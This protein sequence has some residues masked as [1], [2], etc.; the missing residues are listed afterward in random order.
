MQKISIEEAIEQI[1]KK[2]PR[3]P[4]ESYHFIREI[5]DFTIKHFKKNTLGSDRHVS[6]KELLEGVRLYSLQ[7][8]GPLAF[9]VLT[10]WNLR[11]C[12]DIG[13]VV[14]N[15]VSMRI[16]KTTANDSRDD[17]KNGYHFEEALRKPF[18]PSH[19]TSQYLPSRVAKLGSTHSS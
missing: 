1:V 13:E 9:T 14:Y 2:D 8:F 11:T 16:L 7:E 10:E 6:G 17:F 15:M 12:E 18:E 3:Y 19:S 5:L 4:K